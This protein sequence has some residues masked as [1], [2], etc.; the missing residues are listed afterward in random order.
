MGQNFANIFMLTACARSLLRTITVTS[1]K[2]IC[3]LGNQT[4]RRL[5]HMSPTLHRTLDTK[6]SRRVLKV[7]YADLRYIMSH[8]QESFMVIDVRRPDQ[9]ET[10]TIPGSLNIPLSD[11]KYACM[12]EKGEFL[13]KYNMPKPSKENIMLILSGLGPI[14]R[15]RHLRLHI[16][17]DTKS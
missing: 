17:A 11:L 3:P 1:Q 2:Q 12:L 13:T 16:K 15:W 8:F 9:A 14:R 4:G 6:T 7:D 10:G 5:R